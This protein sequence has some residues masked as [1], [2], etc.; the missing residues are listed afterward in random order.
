MNKISTIIN[1]AVNNYISVVSENYN[2]DAKELKKLWDNKR[3][4]S[5]GKKSTYNG[6]KFEDKINNENILLNLGYVKEDYYLLKN[7]TDKRYIFVIQNGFKKYMK[8]KYNIN[9]IRLP[10]EAYIIEYKTGKV[11]IK[12]LE[13]KSQNIQGSVETKL[14]ASPSLKR[15]YELILGNKF[16]ISYA[17]SVNSYLQKLLISS[18]I[19]YRTLMNILYENNIEVLYGDDTDYFTKIDLWINK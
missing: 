17:L 6:K 16:N 18:H 14:W 8:N 7:D 12:I 2:I 3:A 4:N 9:I 10:D 1:E 5:G 13:K 19:K 15:E 11:D